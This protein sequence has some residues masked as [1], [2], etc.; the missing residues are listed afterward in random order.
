MLNIYGMREV[1]RLIIEDCTEDTRQ[2]EGQPFTGKVLGPEFGK[3][4]AQIA[5]L[6]D[7]IDK[8][9]KEQGMT[10]A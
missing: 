3:I 9:L 8:M 4:R 6:A 5:A 7:T 1:M 2:L 10:D